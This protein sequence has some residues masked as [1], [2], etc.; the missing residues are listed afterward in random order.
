MQKQRPHPSFDSREDP[1]AHH[2]TPLSAQPI[3]SSSYSGGLKPRQ[4]HASYVVRSDGT[5]QFASHKRKT[6]LQGALPP[7]YDGSASQTSLSVPRG[8]FLAPLSLSLESTPADAA[9][10][11]GH[12]A[13]GSVAPVEDALL[14]AGGPR[15]QGSPSALAGSGGMSLDDAAARGKVAPQDEGIQRFA[16][17]GVDS[18]RP[19]DDARLIVPSA[20]LGLR[21]SALA[22]EASLQERMKLLKEKSKNMSRF[23]FGQRAQRVFN[24]V[25]Y[26]LVRQ[27]SVQCQERA[28][29][30]ATLWVRSSDVI[31]ALSAMFL[32]EQDRH[33]QEEG[34]LKSDLRLARKDYLT[35]VQRLE[36]MVDDEYSAQ[37]ALLAES[38]ARESQLCEEMNSLKDELLAAKATIQKM[39]REH[40]VQKFQLER[41]LPQADSYDLASV[42]GITSTGSAP[43]DAPGPTTNDTS[44]SA[45]EPTSQLVATLKAELQRQRVLL[46]HAA[47]EIRKLR[48]DIPKPHSVACEAK[49]ST[50]DTGVD[51][52]EELM[53]ESESEA[54]ED[55]SEAASKRGGRGGR[56]S[57]GRGGRGR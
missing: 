8:K 31:N 35:V 51:P 19:E 12:R 39:E 4:S 10:L 16:V 20:N 25:A 13:G 36:R 32:V 46:L 50:V 45:D 28:R 15:G 56:G 37:S 21:Q 23:E 3:P 5:L 44:D 29:L 22:L 18:V 47:D 57:R 2:S 30:L 49:P 17:S 24:D 52:C 42:L 26:E 14:S 53:T 41:P 54:E 43:T 6:T 7:G 34:R 38:E 11:G 9:L 48:G 55:V 33:H 40:R 1:H 27:V